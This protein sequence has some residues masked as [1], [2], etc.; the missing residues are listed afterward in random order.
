MTRR[1]KGFSLVELLVAMTLGLAIAVAA[2]AAVTTVLRTLTRL[3]LRAEAEDVLTLGL[4]AFTLDVRRAGFD[5][6]GVGLA[7]VVDASAGR[8]GLQ[9]DLDGDGAVDATSEESTAIACDLPGGRLSRIVGAQSLPLANG[10][11]GCALEYVD[12]TGAAIPVPGGGLDA[13]ARRRIRAATLAV[14]LRPPGSTVAAARRAT[15]A[16]RSAP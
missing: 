12:A 7:P 6:R 10:V 3:A 14:A 15:V 2:V 11:V 4:E 9:A 16:L 1:S 8:L 13:T 5:P